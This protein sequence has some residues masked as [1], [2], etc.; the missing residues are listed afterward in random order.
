[1]CAEGANFFLGVSVSR[2]VL[3]TTTSTSNFTLLPLIL[4]QIP[5]GNETDL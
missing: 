2:K 5:K 4:K 1:M 3:T